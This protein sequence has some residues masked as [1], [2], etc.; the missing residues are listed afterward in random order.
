L[1]ARGYQRAAAFNNPSKHNG[2]AKTVR[3]GRLSPQLDKW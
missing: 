2:T 3:E 1:I